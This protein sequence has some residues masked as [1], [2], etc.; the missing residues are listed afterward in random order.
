MQNDNNNGLLTLY[1]DQ[2]GD[3]YSAEQQILKALPKMAQASTHPKLRDAFQQHEQQT[4]EHVQRL[5][6]VF[7]KL[8]RKP[9]NETCKAMAGIISEG[10]DMMNKYKDH[11]VL[12]AALIAAAQ[13]VEHYEM[14]GYGTVCAFADT[15]GYSDQN[16]LLHQTLENEEATD[17]KLTEIADSTV[18]ADAMRHQTA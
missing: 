4:R 15:L 2:L 17:K 13:R 16:A 18:N 8:G 3:L 12:D 1:A 9:G 6:Q 10:Q 5:D 7:Q 14:A 11:D